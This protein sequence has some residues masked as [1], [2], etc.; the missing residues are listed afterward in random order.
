M[1]QHNLLLLRLFYLV[2]MLAQLIG[3]VT[4]Q[5]SL[6]FHVILRQKHTMKS[7]HVPAFDKRLLRMASGNANESLKVM[8]PFPCIPLEYLADY[9]HLW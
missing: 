8:V 3:I 2:L 1:T 9:K 7:A 6:V 4:D 5:K